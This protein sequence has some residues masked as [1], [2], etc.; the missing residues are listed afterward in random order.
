MKIIRTI[1]A[2]RE[3]RMEL[4]TDNPRLNI[5]L[6][7]TMGYLH[8]GHLSMVDHARQECDLVVMSIFVNPLQFGAD[9]DFADYPRNLE[10]DAQKAQARGVDVIFAP[11]TNEM[12][13]SAAPLTT[14]SVRELS[15]VMCGKSRPGH[16][17][18]V[19]TVVMKLFQ[20]IQPDYAYFGLKDAQQ[21]AIIEQMVND[22]NVPVHIRP[23][24]II[25]ESDGLALSSR[26]VYLSTDERKQATVLYRSLKNAYDAVQ[27]GER[28]P[29]KIEERIRTEIE[30]APLAEIDYVELRTYPGLQKLDYLQQTFI[31]ALA[32][33]FGKA[34]LIDNIVVHIDNDGR[35]Q[36]C[37]VKC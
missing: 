32:V 11:S 1:K 12:Y 36:Q 15:D 9:E 31:I 8:E 20:I 10:Q 5:G 33:K 37:G 17:D 4:L 6:I 2:W 23:C 27:K 3:Q 13:P 19:A 16:F 29:G 21:V 7:P 30:G 18:G 34:R 14:V 26:N 35:V 22:L 28:R 24:P 25:R